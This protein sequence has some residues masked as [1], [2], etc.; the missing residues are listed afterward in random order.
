MFNLQT[1]LLLF[2]VNI[3]KPAIYLSGAPLGA[4]VDFTTLEILQ[5]GVPEKIIVLFP[6]RS[7]SMLLVAF[8]LNGGKVS[9]SEA[10]GIKFGR[11][12]KFDI[13]FFCLTFD[14]DIF[15]VL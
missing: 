8:A 1:S 4:R 3:Y 11:L 2:V 14:Y 12:V 5:T 6:T 7:A 13:K 15:G 10:F 9:D